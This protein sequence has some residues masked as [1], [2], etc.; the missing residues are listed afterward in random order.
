MTTKESNWSAS[1]P[2][3]TRTEALTDHRSEI[4]ADLG[5]EE[6]NKIS[7]AYLALEL[8]LDL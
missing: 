4:I 2:K 8:E 5:Y 3:C 6:N 1:W 7:Y